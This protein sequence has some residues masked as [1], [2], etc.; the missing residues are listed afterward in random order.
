[1]RADFRQQV[2]VPALSQKKRRKILLD[3]RRKCTEYFELTEIPERN[4]LPSVA[5]IP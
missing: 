5:E 3:L 2:P 4:P 1:L